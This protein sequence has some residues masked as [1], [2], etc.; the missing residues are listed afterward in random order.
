MYGNSG[1][2]LQ[3]FCKS[4]IILKLRVYF[5]NEEEE[6]TYSSSR[7]LNEQSTEI[8]KPLICGWSA[9]GKQEGTEREGAVLEASIF[10]SMTFDNFDAEKGRIL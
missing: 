9:G 1:L 6:R 4:I 10:Q 5:K 8:G 7:E 3:L 2:S